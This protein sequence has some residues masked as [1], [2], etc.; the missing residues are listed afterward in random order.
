[1]ARDQAAGDSGQAARIRVDSQ[2]DL[3]YLMQEIGLHPAMAAIA[4]AL[5]VGIITSG[6]CE[7]SDMG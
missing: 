2:P 3:F 4:C 7:G 6:P 1:M 5:A